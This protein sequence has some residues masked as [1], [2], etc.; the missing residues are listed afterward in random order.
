MFNQNKK[1]NLSYLIDPRFT[2][3]NRFF[4]SSFENKGYRRSFSEYY[5]P[6]VDTKDFNVLIDEKSFFWHSYKK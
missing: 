4:V 6:S 1:I 2:K 3:V 5:T